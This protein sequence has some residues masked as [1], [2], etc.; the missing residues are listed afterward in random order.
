MSSFG[1]VHTLNLSGCNRITDVN[2]LG[3]VHTLNLSGC[4]G[5][6]DFSSLLENVHTLDLNLGN[7]H[8]LYADIF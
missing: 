2:S 3:N 4:N 8:A 1:N 5:I 6:K 7:V